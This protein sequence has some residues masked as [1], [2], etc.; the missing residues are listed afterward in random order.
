MSSVWLS[1]CRGLLCAARLGSRW[2][3]PFVRSVFVP[4]S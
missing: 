1:V 4:G 2:S 3:L